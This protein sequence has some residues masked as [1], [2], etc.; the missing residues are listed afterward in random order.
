MNLE[1]F[2]PLFDVSGPVIS[3]HLDTSREDQD[4][5]KRIQ[6]EWRNLRQQLERQGADPATLDVIEAEVG[7]APEVVGPQGESLFAADGRLLGAYTL[8]APPVRNRA[9]LAPIADAVDTVL[10]YDRQLPHVVVAIDRQGGD[11]DAYEAGTL[12]AARSRSYSGSTLHI[13]RVKAGGPSKASYHRRTENVWSAN[14]AGVADEIVAAVEA[15]KAAVIFVG[16]DDKATAALRGQPALQQTGV[17]LVDVSGGRGGGD[18]KDTLRRSVDDA[19]S[20]ASRHAHADAFARFEQSAA[21]GDAISSIPAVAEALGDGRVHTLMLSSNFPPGV[22]KWS[23]TSKPLV[24]ASARGALGAEAHEA[25]ETGAAALML[26]AAVLS[27]AEFLE[28]PTDQ[29]VVDGTAA[30]LRY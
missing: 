2:R 19:L 14:A 16:G 4:A 23:T 9:V 1:L 24:V 6:V 20:A 8:A 29:E 11:I 12:D 10:D 13:T 17:T 3:V 18:A 25:F 21:S 22:M 5:G 26:R 15:V 30:F 28:I 7:G 27:D